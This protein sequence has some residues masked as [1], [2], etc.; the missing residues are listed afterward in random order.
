[1]GASQAKEKG[2]DIS[3]SEIE[4]VFMKAGTLMAFKPGQ[5]LVHQG[6]RFP[7]L[8]L[9]INGEVTLMQAAEDGTQRE[10]GTR[11]R[12]DVVGELSFLL[13]T[14]P[15]VDVL[16]PA[17]YPRE[18]SVVEV[19]HHRAI[20]LLQHDPKFAS[21]VFQTL[22]GVL[23]NRL[24]TTS[25]LKKTAAT[26][27]LSQHLHKSGPEVAATAGEAIPPQRFGLELEA[28]YLLQAECMVMIEE[29]TTNSDADGDDVRFNALLALFSTHLCLEL[30]ALSF[31]NQRVIALADV[32]GIEQDAGQAPLLIVSCRGLTLHITLEANIFADVSKELELARLQAFDVSSIT[33]GLLT[34]C[35]PSCGPPRAAR[36]H[37]TRRLNL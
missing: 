35:L 12:M 34:R 14:T 5:V 26:L 13:D 19:T 7:N 25:R 28:E 23:A 11:G 36:P 33:H 10:L 16:V 2:G 24:D 32:I 31:T 3:W 30:K 4:H 6:H 21:K 1:M 18:V 17:S 37:F 8:Y 15:A 27:H 29:R 22:A 20:S 9:I